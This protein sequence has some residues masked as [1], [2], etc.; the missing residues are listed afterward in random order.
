M[1]HH[2]VMDDTQR[3]GVAELLRA[4]QAFPS[5]RLATMAELAGRR[6]VRA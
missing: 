4:L 2:A 6:V 3:G 1:L 5:A